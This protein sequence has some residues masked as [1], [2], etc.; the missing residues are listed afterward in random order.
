MLAKIGTMGFVE[1]FLANVRRKETPFYGFVYSSAKAVLHWHLPVPSFLRP[2]FRTVYFLHFAVRG[3]YWQ[4]LIFFYSG[5]IF[6]ARCD[7]VGKNLVVSRL[8]DVPGN[9]RLIIGDNVHLNGFFSA[10][11]SRLFENPT[12][13]IGNNVHI[14]HMVGFVVNKAI[15]LEDGVMIASNCYFADSD[16][17][18][19]DPGRRTRGEPPS[20]EDVK[21]IVICRNAWIGNNAHI[22]KGVTVGEG[23]IVAAG[24]VVAKDVPPF[25][26]VAGNPARVVVE[27]LLL[28]IPR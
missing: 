24:S 2:V 22:L 18:P 13:R 10:N 3:L 23:A 1:S 5:P 27:N 15:T 14:G 9:L 25:A 4:T 8:P 28:R 21:P 12:L 26:I 6:R 7:S 16:A 11:S 20:I 17:H 19:I